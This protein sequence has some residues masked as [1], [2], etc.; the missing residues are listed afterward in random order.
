MLKMGKG[1]DDMSKSFITKEEFIHQWLQHFAKEIPKDKL[2]KYVTNQYIWHIFSW[3]LIGADCYLSG[4]AA[5]LAYDNVD[6]SNCIFCET[7]GG[8]G[9][10]V[11]EVLLNA[12]SSSKSIDSQVTE[13][14]VVAKDY[15]WTYIKTHEGDFCGPYFMKSY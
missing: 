4:D 13:L 12:Y 3:K 1:G 8:R 15:S 11:T 5:R 2:Q 10:G 7:F 14:Y 6:K 9:K